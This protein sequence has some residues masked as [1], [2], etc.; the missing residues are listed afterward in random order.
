MFLR[1]EIVLF[2]NNTDNPE[3]KPGKTM[4]FLE[5]RDKLDLFEAIDE[6]VHPVV[7]HFWEM[8]VK[9]IRLLIQILL[10]MVVGSALAENVQRGTEADVNNMI[11]DALAYIKEVGVEKA[12]KEFDD[13]DNKRWHYMDLYIFCEKMD[14]MMDCH[15]A[16]KAL[17]GKN[18]FEMQ[19]VD[20]QYF[21][22]D[23]IDIVRSNGSGWLNYKRA[24]PLTKQVEDKKVFV[25]K[26]PDYDGF[27]GTGIYRPIAD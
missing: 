11:V 9:A 17:V 18:L 21:V 23:C 1:A 6:S 3:L 5:T 27:I 16:N 12:F 8:A 14:G 19:T 15:G 13:Q 4:L 22:K 20:G 7:L 26:V 24:N 2:I 10:F 25:T